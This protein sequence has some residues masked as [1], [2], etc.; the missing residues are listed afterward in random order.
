LQVGY[1]EQDR[2]AET[3]RLI[4]TQ[5]PTAQVLPQLSGIKQTAWKRLF[6]ELTVLALRNLR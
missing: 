4:A 2:F 5:L 6:A 1:G 3:N